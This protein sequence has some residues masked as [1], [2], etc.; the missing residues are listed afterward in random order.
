MQ[1]Y[2]KARTDAVNEQLLQQSVQEMQPGDAQ[3]YI[4]ALAQAAKRCPE[5]LGRPQSL[6]GL[7]DEAYALKASSIARVGNTLLSI[8][9]VGRSPDPERQFAEMRRITELAVQRFQER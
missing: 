3:R 2:R 7:G 8:A 6:E 9:W 4:Q 5:A 1:V